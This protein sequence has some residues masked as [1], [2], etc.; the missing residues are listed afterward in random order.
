MIIIYQN[1]F[2]YEINKNYTIAIKKKSAI[3]IRI[4]SGY[5]T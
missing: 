4:S 2:I 1:N 3:F 5:K